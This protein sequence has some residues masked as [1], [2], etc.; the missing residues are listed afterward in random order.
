MHRS[1]IKPP[2]GLC[3][4]RR[5]SEVA[6]AV[7]ITTTGDQLALGLENGKIQLYA[8]ENSQLGNFLD[9]FEGHTQPITDLT[10][11][12]LGERLASASWDSNILLW[13]VETGEMIR[14]ADHKRGV[15]DVAFSPN[16]RLLASVGWD[17]QLIV[18]DLDI[19]SWRQIACQVANRHL[20]IEE[21]HAY[22]S[23]EPYELLCK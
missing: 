7:A 18:W 6:T 15:S 20:T 12:H 4:R 16:G 9:D 13:Q 10:F 8:F 23:N 2:G 19:D 1:L 22:L 11:D 3:Q 5:L 21:W 17:N 14:L